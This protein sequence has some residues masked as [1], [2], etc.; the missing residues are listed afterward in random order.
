MEKE[1]C[2]KIEQFGYRAYLVGGCVRDFLLGVESA[3][4]DIATDA[5]LSVLD[6]LFRTYDVGNGRDF[7]I[8]VVHTEAGDYE[9]AQF[10]ADGAYSDDGRPDDVKLGVTFEADTSRRDFTINA[11]G[12]DSNGEVIDY[13]G[14]RKDLEAGLI[15]TVGVASERFDEDRVRMIRAV[16]FAARYGFEI[17]AE[18][19]RAIKEMAS[20]I[21][22][23]P[24]ERITA[25]LWKMASGDNFS[26]ALELLSELGL[27]G[28]ILP[29]MERFKGYEHNLEHHPEG[30]VW[31][32]VMACIR[33]AEAW[34]AETKFAVL[35][36]DV[37]KPDCYR[38]DSER[39]HTY[40]GHEKFG[41][42]M[43]DG[44]A[45]RMKFSNE[46]RDVCKFAAE[47]HMK[48]H[49][50]DRLKDSKVMR[51]ME[52]RWFSVLMRV[53][54]AD[55]GCRG[56][57]LRKFTEGLKRVEQLKKRMQE[58]GDL[59]AVRKAV[60]GELVMRLTGLRQGKELGEVIRRAVEL[61][62]ERGV[63]VDDREAVERIILEV[64]G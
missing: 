53:A 11:M 41:A 15:R 59:K 58:L 40:D 8:V 26:G 64:R 19:A 28:H 35:F 46:L 44:I 38:W 3:D 27:L 45:R 30:G 13:H 49:E 43:L 56:T 31:A 48:F 22:R 14:G 6:S 23:V 5:P 4:I 37:G 55:E 18:T 50:L 2:Q 9:V 61:M 63:S 24:M 29:E 21:V 7:G 1:I 25:E 36:H 54:E 62:I 33:Y 52:S 16:R 12:M 34:D 60:N 10:R 51:L 32:H 57:G 17:E 47:H 39:G 42:S 20:E